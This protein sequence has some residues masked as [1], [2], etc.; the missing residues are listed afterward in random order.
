MICTAKRMNELEM[1][2]DAV[3]LEIETTMPIL[4]FGSEAS[5]ILKQVANAFDA[6]DVLD[7]IKDVSDTEIV[8]G[9]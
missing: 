3:L 7:C 6:R 2:Q 4:Q 8:K 1:K 5:N 9:E